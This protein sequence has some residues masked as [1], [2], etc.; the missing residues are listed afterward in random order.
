[1]AM[2]LCLEAALRSTTLILPRPELPTAILRYRPSET[3]IKFVGR[4]GGGGGDSNDTE[5]I[6]GVEHFSSHIDQ[7]FIKGFLPGK[8]YAT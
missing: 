7:G 4:W 2:G 1:M 8:I 3:R 6:Q 5:V